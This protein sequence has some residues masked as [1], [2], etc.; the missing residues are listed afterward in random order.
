M[1]LWMCLINMG[2]AQPTMLHGY[3]SKIV[4]ESVCVQ[5]AELCSG[6]ADRW[7]RDCQ[8]FDWRCIPEPPAA[9]EEK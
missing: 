6:P 8:D 9:S 3:S 5:A 7:V 2:Y 4:C 1:M